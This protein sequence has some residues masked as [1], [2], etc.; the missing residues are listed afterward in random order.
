MSS[1]DEDENMLDCGRWESTSKERAAGNRLM[2]RQ[3]I[4]AT[5]SSL[6]RAFDLNGTPLQT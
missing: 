6:N 5:F 1:F 4:F 2:R 3:V